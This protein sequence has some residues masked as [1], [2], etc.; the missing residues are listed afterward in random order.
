MSVSACKKARKNVEDYYP[1]VTTVS[2]SVTGDGNVEVSA[3]VTLK[4]GQLQYIGFCM[5]TVPVPDMVK[6]QVIVKELNGSSFRHTY[7]MD[8]NPAKNYYF[9]SW[10]ASETGY[11]YGNVVSLS[12]IRATPASAPCD[13]TLNTSDIGLGGSGNIYKVSSVSNFSSTWDI[14]T[15]G[16]D[17]RA[18]NLRFSFGSPLKTKVYTTSSSYL[19]IY[20]D[21]V[22]ISV[23]G[24]FN[25]GVVKAGTK[26]YVNKLS[27]GVFEITVCDASWNAT[28]SSLTLDLK[29]RFRSPL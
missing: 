16:Y 29:T 27:E 8:F 5:D 28:G 22:F 25:S 3:D 13:L 15:S 4:T 19:S 20:S 14:N 21:N 23:S 7:A 24:G 12:N 18:G 10:A 17:S 1:K 9:R 11:S 6:N 26:V 2:A